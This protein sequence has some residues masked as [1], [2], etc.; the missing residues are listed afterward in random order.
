MLEPRRSVGRRRLLGGLSAAGITAI[1]GCSASGE[2]AESHLRVGTLQPPV[3]LD[4]IRAKYVGS[5][6]AI[7]KLFDGLYAYGEGAT[8]RPRI[9]AG[10]PTYEGDRTVVVE[11]DDDARFHDGEPVTPDDVKYSFEAPLAED[12]AAKAD[13][14]AVGSVEA[15]DD[16]TVRFD[17]DH[18]AP[19]FEGALTTPIVPRD[20][21]EED[22]E[23]FARNPVGAGPYELR[24]FS[25]GK[26]VRLA[27]WPEHR[28]DP[29]PAIDRV[30]IV[31]VESPITQMMSLRTGRSDMVEPVSPQLRTRVRDVTGA[32]VTTR[33]GYRLYYLGFNVNEGPTTKR[34]VREAIARCIDLDRAVEEYIAPLGRRLYGPLPPRVT[35]EWDMPRE[36]W[37]SLA[38]SKDVDEA[39]RLLEG[40]DEGSGQLTILTSKDPKW[41]EIGERLARGLREAGR[42]ALVKSVSWKTYLERY[43]SGAQRDYSVFVGEVAG[44]PDPDAFLYPAV[45][46]NMQGITNGVFY[47]ED[48]VMNPL[49]EARRTTDRARRRELYA[50]A[51]R[52][53][54]EDRAIVPICSFENSFAHVRSIRGFRVHPIPQLNPRVVSPNGAMTIGEP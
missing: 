9:A 19:A 27:R 13:V 22:P 32:S 41:K 7:G 49:L 2:S 29:G 16:L 48:A 51:I 44:P 28:G 20:V 14:G 36:E 26:A 21:R 30:T 37:R 6:Q 50:S 47:T 10:P 54:L 40:A 8:V 39:R 4:P 11:L 46:E 34:A 15:V 31:H 33:E 53:L 5:A 52:R 3:T 35:E 43:V 38:D 24:S 1:A 23:A 12:T 17:L 25:E 45:H 42:G 18:P